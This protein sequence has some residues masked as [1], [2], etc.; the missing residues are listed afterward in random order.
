MTECL[1][2]TCSMCSGRF[3]IKHFRIHV[4][5]LIFLQRFLLDFFIHIYNR[6]KPDR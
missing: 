6:M 1:S 5:M 2:T 4:Y 3:C